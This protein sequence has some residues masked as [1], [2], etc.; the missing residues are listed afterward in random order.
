MRIRY[1]TLGLLLLTLCIFHSGCSSAQEYTAYY[2][3]YFD[4]FSTLTVYAES[5]EEFETYRQIVDEVFQ[6]YHRLC[7]AYEPFDSVVNLYTLNQSAGQ[8]PVAVEAPLYEFLEYCVDAYESSLGT[9]NIALGS[10]LQLWQEQM[11]ADDPVVPSEEALAQAAQHTDISQMILDP[12]SQTVELLDPEM[13]LDAGA[14]AKGYATAIAQEQLIEAGCE[15]ALLNAGGNIVCIGTYPGLNGWNVGI[16]NPDT[17]SETSL[18]TTWLVRDACVVTSGDYE[19]YFEVDGVRYHHI[20]D[21]DALYPANRYH[22]V[23]IQC[24]DAAAADMLSTALFILPRE[25]GEALAAQYHA[26]VLYID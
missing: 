2:F 15:S 21:P 24:T 9:V 18:Y 19:R 4:T 22:S 5:E 11:N 10:V 8:G 6:E 26:Q 16:L 17:S 13:S 20:I 7:N 25:E 14:L 23:S 12:D 3:D 1:M